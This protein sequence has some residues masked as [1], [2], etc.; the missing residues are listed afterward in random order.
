MHLLL[1]MSQIYLFLCRPSLQIRQNSNETE[2]K[3]E[4]AM[5]RRVKEHNQLLIE[6]VLKN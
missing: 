6:I 4:C 2:L 1:L 3:S 5:K